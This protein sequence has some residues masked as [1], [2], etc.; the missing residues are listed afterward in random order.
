MIIAR[1]GGVAVPLVPIDMIQVTS[2]KILGVTISDDLR[3]WQPAPDRPMRY[4]WLDRT[5][6]RSMRCIL[7]PAVTTVARLLYAA[8]TWLVYASRDD[9]T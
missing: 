1:R 9:K 7:L 2:M 8:P 3:S 6:S 5:V 4:G